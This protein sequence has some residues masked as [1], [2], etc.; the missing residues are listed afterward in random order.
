VVADGADITTLACCDPPLIIVPDNGVA[1]FREA[2]ISS[3]TVAAE[4]HVPLDGGLQ[5]RFVIFRDA[6]GGTSVGAQPSQRKRRF[7][8]TSLSAD[9]VG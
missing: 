7:Q 8:A 3:I 5:A 4:A 1:Q 9:V 6:I 2:A